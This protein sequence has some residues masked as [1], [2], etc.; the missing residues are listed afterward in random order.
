[1]ANQ[2]LTPGLATGGDVLSIE[3]LKKFSDELMVIAPRYTH[4]D[5][6]N[7]LI[8]AKFISSDNFNFQPLSKVLGGV[9]VLAVY[10]YRSL[11]SS[12][13]FLNKHDFDALYLTGDFFCNS[14]PATFYKILNPKIKIFCNFYHLNP[15]PWKRENRF[16]NSLVSFILQRLSLTLIR[17]ISDHIFVLSEEGR[18]NL[19]K[20]GFGRNKITISGAGVSEQFTRKTKQFKKEYDL[21]FIG[22]LNKTKGIYDALEVLKKVKKSFKN[23]KMAIVGSC[24]EDELIKINS[25]NANN[26]LK[27]NFYY[28]GYTSNE[29]KNRLMETTPILLAPSHEEGFGIGILEG[30]ASGMKIVA[31]DLSVYKL[32]FKKYKDRIIYSRIG[33][34]TSMANSVCRLMGEKISSNK[35]IKVT[36]WNEVANIQRIII[37]KSL[38]RNEKQ[39]L[40]L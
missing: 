9:G 13:Y 1:M 16:I 6:Q 22:R 39:P 7:V 12:I 18:N 17:K 31:Y 11:T 36:T 40:K 33:D 34:T 26:K 35:S 23:V 8:N 15:N 5:L 21:L 19:I 25:Y 37:T 4:L 38:Y 2:L 27:N 28:L 29:V 3:V 30:I 10:F 14:I 32:I 20:L 24:A